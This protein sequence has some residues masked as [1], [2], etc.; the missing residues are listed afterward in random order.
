MCLYENP[1]CEHSKEQNYR[2]ISSTRE[3]AK[4]Q[5]SSNLPGY[6]SDKIARNNH[7]MDRPSCTNEMDY[8]ATVNKSRWWPKSTTTIKTPTPISSKKTPTLPTSQ[9]TSPPARTM[10]NITSEGTDSKKKR[11][12]EE[13]GFI[14]N[15]KNSPMTNNTEVPVE[16]ET[17]L[18]SSISKEKHHPP[19]LSNGIRKTSQRVMKSAL[20]KVGL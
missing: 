14:T 10:T 13:T 11:R 5:E 17:S 16:A 1:P 15:N 3:T 9:A 8:P 2:M 19:M 18:F 7:T 4:E 6:S 20:K 12:S